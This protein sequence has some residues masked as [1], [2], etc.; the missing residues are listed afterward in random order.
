MEKKMKRKGER[1]KDKKKDTILTHPPNR[2]LRLAESSCFNGFGRRG[3]WTILL[4]HRSASRT[5]TKAL[6]SW[7]VRTYT[8]LYSSSDPWCHVLRSE[9]CQTSSFAGA[10]T[11][12][13]STAA[14]GGTAGG[15]DVPD[16]FD[17]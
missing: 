12:K 1:Q 6:L 9:C 13:A 15:G 17:V 3:M 11:S 2:P 5:W 8:K 16:V 14:G 4:K 7:D 10:S